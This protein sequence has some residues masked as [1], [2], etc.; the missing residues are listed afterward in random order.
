MYRNNQPN[1][2]YS[3]HSLAWLHTCWPPIT[4]PKASQLRALWKE[5]FVACLSFLRYSVVPWEFEHQLEFLSSH[6]QH[7]HVPYASPSFLGRVPDEATQTLLQN[8]DLEPISDMRKFNQLART[9]TKFRN[10]YCDVEP[11]NLQYY[12]QMTQEE[13]LQSMH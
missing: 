8:R 7:T 3:R 1:Q 2:T 11:I 4:Q 10:N 6:T 5:R 12:N 9:L 13:L